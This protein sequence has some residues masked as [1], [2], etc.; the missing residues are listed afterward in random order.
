MRATTAFDRIIAIDGVVI[1]GVTFAPEGVVVG[2]RRRKRVHQCPCGVT[3]AAHY[4]HSTRRWRHLDLGVDEVA[5]H[6]R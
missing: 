3:T 5:R 4:D 6:D 2:V 1:S